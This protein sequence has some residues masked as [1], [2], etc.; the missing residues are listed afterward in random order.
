MK[1]IYIIVLAFFLPI[2][3]FGQFQVGINS[4]YIY[5]F[6]TKPNDEVHICDYDYTHNA[7]SITVS[8]KQR[9]E[10]IFNHSIGLKYTNRSFT[11]K[12]TTGGHFGSIKKD[13]H[14]NIGNI[15]IQLKPEFDFGSKVRFFFYPGIGFGTIVHSSLDGTIYSSVLGES[16]IDTISGSAS[17]YYPNFE[18]TVLVGFGIEFPVYNNLSCVIDNGLSMNLL[19]IADAW[20]SG[21]TKMF[22][23]N[24]LV[25]LAYTFNRNKSESG[26]KEY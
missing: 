5:Y 8:V 22:D 9:S 2:I 24:F 18:L 19:P 4:G 21:K 6:F 12:S 13:Y 10:N 25:G 23:L 26:N 14:Y 16:N 17:E 15:F 20:G 1:I 11:A 3:S 7:F